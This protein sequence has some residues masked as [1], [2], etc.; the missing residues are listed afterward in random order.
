MFY[1][2]SYGNRQGKFDDVE[3]VLGE[4]CLDFVF[5]YCLCW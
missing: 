1:M 2:Q 4:F 5:V 3:R